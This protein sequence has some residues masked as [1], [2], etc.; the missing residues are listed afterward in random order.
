[1][2][3][4]SKQ[5]PFSQINMVPYLDVMLVLLI[6]F[7]IVVP[8]VQTGVSI[9][10]PKQGGEAQ[11]S[12]MEKTI[13]LTIDASG[14]RFLQKGE[15]K[16]QAVADLAAIQSWFEANQCSK[17]AVIQVK[18]DKSLVWDQLMMSMAQLQKLGWRKL[19]LMT[20]QSET[21]L[22]KHAISGS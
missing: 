3:L 10:L 19:A 7:M 5:A 18:A 16:P 11:K 2:S 6:I 14:Q 4:K 13:V 15:S 17:D 8:A 1:M 9:E 22:K 21:Q 12:L 20:S